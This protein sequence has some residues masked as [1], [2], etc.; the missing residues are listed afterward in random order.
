M[1]SPWMRY[2]LIGKVL[3]DNKYYERTDMRE[4]L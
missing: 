2:V 3:V 4:L 1:L